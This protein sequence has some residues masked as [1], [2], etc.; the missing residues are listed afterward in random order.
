MMRSA[1]VFVPVMGRGAPSRDEDTSPHTSALIVAPAV[2]AQYRA[3][4]TLGKTHAKTFQARM[5]G[6]L[7]TYADGYDIPVLVTRNEQNE[8]NKQNELTEPVA[9]VAHTATVGSDS[10]RRATEPHAVAL[11][12]QTRQAPSAAITSTMS[13]GTVW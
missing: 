13:R 8:R 11:P 4:D 1:V 12:V 3:D 7:S 2:D 9:N 10:F 6:R 5:L